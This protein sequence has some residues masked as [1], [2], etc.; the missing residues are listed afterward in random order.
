[1]Q[2]HA[3]ITSIISMTP[4]S[5]QALSP[6]TPSSVLSAFTK[7]LFSTIPQIRKTPLSVGDYTDLLAANPFAVTLRLITSEDDQVI[8]S[9]RP[10]TILEWSCTASLLPETDVLVALILAHAVRVPQSSSSS[11][12]DQDSL[13]YALS[14]LSSLPD[15][16]A[17]PVMRLLVET[18]A[19]PERVYDHSPS[20]TRLAGVTT[21]RMS[22]LSKAVTPWENGKHGRLKHGDNAKAKVSLLLSLG[23]SPNS[24]KS[25]LEGPDDTFTPLVDEPVYTW[26][27]EILSLL[28]DAGVLLRYSTFLAADLAGNL[29]PLLSLRPRTRTTAFCAALTLTQTSSQLTPEAALSS[30]AV[31]TLSAFAKGDPFC[32]ASCSGPKFLLCADCLSVG[33][34]NKACQATLWK[35]HKVACKHLKGARKAREEKGG[36]GGDGMYEEVLRE[37][38]KFRAVS[39]IVEEVEGLTEEEAVEKWEERRKEEG[40]REREG[41]GEKG[42]GVRGG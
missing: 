10:L 3:P 9:S 40:G 36:E 25:V 22:A 4:S 12:A 15:V 8:R 14:A 39:G 37:V 29:V 23:A 41:G 38:R 33:F 6:T 42:R 34:C 7:I 26:N 28:L 1:M 27:P 13:D 17:V 31:A 2:T 16:S 19:D 20:P 24:E 18:G 35:D 5:L 11:S 32:C 21:R 30:A